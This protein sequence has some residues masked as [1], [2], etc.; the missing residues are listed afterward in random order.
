[1]YLHHRR[2]LETARERSTPRSSLISGIALLILTLSIPSSLSADEAILAPPNEIVRVPLLLRKLHTTHRALYVTAH[3]DDEDAGLIARLVHGDG[4]DLTLLTLT[5]GNGGQNEIGTELHGAI[6]ALRTAELESAHRYDGATQWFGTADDFGYSFSVEETLENWGESR[7]LRELVGAIRQA[8]PDV[9][10]TMSPDGTGGGQHHQTSARLTER[11]LFIA[12]EETWPELG[13]PHATA[14][15]FAVVWGDTEVE[16]LCEVSLDH[17]DPLLGATYAEIGSRSRSMHK[18]QGM[19]TVDPP[20]PRRSTRLQLRYDRSGVLGELSHPFQDL[21][22]HGLVDRSGNETAIAHSLHRIVDVMREG[23]FWETSPHVGSALAL[24]RLDPL[25]A[26]A[27]RD[28]PN[29]AAIRTLDRHRRE[30]AQHSAGLR[31]RAFAASPFVGL[32]EEAA[33]TFA[34]ENRGNGQIE[35]ELWLDATGKRTE[36]TRWQLAPGERRLETTKLPP[37]LLPTLLKGPIEGEIP[38]QPAAIR[39]A[40]QA[41]ISLPLGE[42]DENPPSQELQLVPIPV[43]AR[44]KDEVF[45]TL[46]STIV[47][48]VPDPSIRPARSQ[49]VAIAKP[50]QAASTHGEFRISTRHAGDVEIELKVEDPRWQLEPTSVVVQSPGAGIEVSVPFAVTAPSG[51]GDLSTTV[52]AEA[53]HLDSSDLGDVWSNRGYRRIEYPH[54]GTTAL[55]ELAEVNVGRIEAQV[56]PK[57][58]GYIEGVGDPLPRA[59]SALGI[60]VTDLKEQDLREGDF[61]SL[62]TIVIG[63]RAY[64]VRR[65]LRAAQ[66]RLMEWIK[67]GGTLVVQYH[68]FEFNAEDGWSPFVPY[69]GAAVGRGRITDEHAPPVIQELDHPL[70]TTP[71]QI[72]PRDW[73]NWIQE[74]GLYFLNVSARTATHYSDLVQFEDPFPYNAGIK[75]G[76]L[77]EAQYGKGRWIYVGLGLW[78]QTPAGVPGAY[79]LLANLLAR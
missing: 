64:K 21:P 17:Y 51:F 40:G 66:G 9:I 79:R 56:I 67:E 70:L 74:R 36:P 65:D 18:C 71:N 32:N 20:L 57:R 6:A 68:K 73:E 7:M 58:V 72:S 10:F 30:A 60:E 23:P 2:E 3:P 77:V 15:L 75:G 8:Q 46:R 35:V 53:R 63:V 59:I 33:V 55:E 5:R 41:T 42:E 62:D 48:V 49:E 52:R 61:S 76:A 50:D 39:L 54:I 22:K 19:V 31:I 16:H 24:L 13:P 37:Q 69:R 11:A 1:M 25:F 27:L 78:R 43:V 44:W 29:S 34:A 45:P 4:V 28:A 47:R 12:A 14:R 26:R 38:A